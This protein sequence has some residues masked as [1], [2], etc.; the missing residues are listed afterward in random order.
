MGDREE[1][2]KK[3]GDPSIRAIP[4]HVAIVMDGNGRW[5]Q[6][7][8][9][10]RSE[11]HRHG[12]DAV[13]R[14]VEAAAKLG[15]ER[16]TLY[17][18]SSENWNRSPEEVDFLMSLF[19]D[20][21]IRKRDYLLEKGVHL[22]VIGRRTNIPET[23]SREMDA[24]MSVTSANPLHRI[25][26]CLAF[27][28]GSRQEI[29]DAVRQIASLVRQGELD[30]EQIDESTISTHLYTSGVP[31]PD[32]LIRTA[33]EQR[34]SNFLLWQI[35]YAELWITPVLWPDFTEADF[36]EAI[37][38][39]SHRTRRFGREHPPTSPPLPPRQSPPTPTR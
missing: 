27:N 32:L 30:P 13:E 16:L 15:V 4:R 9:W 23:L 10:I 3:G 14:V 38:S 18:F 29:T 1:N 28:Y 21:L 6:R 17:C 37:V 2:G 19:R 5:A 31:D 12:S 7:R 35:S 22:S 25:D 8:G 33:G 24:T 39:Y 34:L 26:V 36:H 20:F 11:G